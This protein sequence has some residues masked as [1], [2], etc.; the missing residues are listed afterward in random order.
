M[1]WTPCAED[2]RWLLTVLSLMNDKGVLGTPSSGLVYRIDR[3]AKTMTLIAGDKSR[4]THRRTV[5]VAN[6][7]GWTV[8]GEGDESRNGSTICDAE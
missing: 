2:E 3:P 6:A 5:I 8:E 4:E 7:I 1:S